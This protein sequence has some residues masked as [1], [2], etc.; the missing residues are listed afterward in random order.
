M[1]SDV[2]DLLARSSKGTAHALDR[3]AVPTASVKD[4]LQVVV[5]SQLRSALVGRSLHRPATVLSVDEHDLDRD[6]PV[7][8]YDQIADVLRA[9]IEV[10]QLTGRVPSEPS[11]VQ[12]FGVSR[13]TA[14]RAVQILV[15]A[16]LVTYSPGKGAFVVPPER[17]APRSA[18]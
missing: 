16:G 8:L 1:M 6:S 13:G 11:L 3:E 18:S 17:R 15:D 12:M 5:N 2:G 9:Q 10:G 7:P 14:G 4:S